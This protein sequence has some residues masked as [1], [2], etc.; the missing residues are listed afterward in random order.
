VTG[1]LRPFDHFL[2]KIDKT[3]RKVIHK[4]VKRKTVKHAVNGNTV[5]TT[6]FGTARLSILAVWS[7]KSGVKT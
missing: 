2:N 5:A 3:V 4:T 6:V 7:R 1:V